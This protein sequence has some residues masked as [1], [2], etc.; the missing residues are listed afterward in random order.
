MHVDV[1]IQLFRHVDMEKNMPTTALYVYSYETSDNSKLLNKTCV[2]NT[3]HFGETLF[4]T[5]RMV[6]VAGLR[7]TMLADPL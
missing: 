3:E 6:A 1:E 5:S 2:L 7:L 4:C